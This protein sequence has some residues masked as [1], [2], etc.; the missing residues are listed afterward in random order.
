L[1]TSKDLPVIKFKTP[2]DHEGHTDSELTNLVPKVKVSAVKP[3]VGNWAAL[4]D[5][6]IINYKTWND[7]Q[8]VEDSKTKGDKKPLTFRLGHY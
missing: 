5:W 8:L 7:G 4:D 2:F 1:D 3:G 6:T